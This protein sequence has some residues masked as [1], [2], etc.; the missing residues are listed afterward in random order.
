MDGN[1][2]YAS[3]VHLLQHSAVLIMNPYA[4]SFFFVSYRFFFL[5]SE[6]NRLS[7]V[8]KISYLTMKFVAAK[9][10]TET[11]G[12]RIGIFSVMSFCA[13]LNR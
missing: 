9:N 8:N 7:C 6:F 12:L 5:L 3:K 13:A 4:D 2:G 1:N 11:E 10:V